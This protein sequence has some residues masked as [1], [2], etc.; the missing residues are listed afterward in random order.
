MRR[1]TTDVVTLMLQLLLEEEANVIAADA[2]VTRWLAE[3]D[4]RRKSVNSLKKA[5]AILQ[6]EVES[7]QLKDKAA[8]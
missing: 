7:S 4:K 6:D 1:A 5:L 3:V 8:N 2:E